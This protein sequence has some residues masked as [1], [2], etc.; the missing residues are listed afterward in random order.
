MRRESDL[1]LG[2]ARRR[3][4]PRPRFE[5]VEVIWDFWFIEV[6]ANGGWI[7]RVWSVFHFWIW[8]I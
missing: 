4:N 3:Q 7:G 8:R 5:G 6:R 1:E 2:M